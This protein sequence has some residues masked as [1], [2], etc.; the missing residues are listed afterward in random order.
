MSLTSKGFYYDVSPDKIRWWKTIP[1]QQK[2]EWL[3]EANA[4][5]RLALSDKKKR[6]MEQFRRGKEMTPSDSLEQ[7]AMREDRQK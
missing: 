5:L 4:F 7:P 6:I 3:E 1:H 2:L